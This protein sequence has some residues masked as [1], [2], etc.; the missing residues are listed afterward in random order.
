MPNRRW[1]QNLGRLRKLQGPLLCSTTSLA[2]MQRLLLQREIHGLF[3][4]HKMIQLTALF[5]SYYLRINDLESCEQVSHIGKIKV[6]ETILCK[7]NDPYSKRA[8]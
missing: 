2:E 4:K 1:E 5:I 6:Q 3:I 8:L 7:A